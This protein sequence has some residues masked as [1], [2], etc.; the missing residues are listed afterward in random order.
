MKKAPY[1]PLYAGEA[2]KGNEACLIEYTVGVFQTLDVGGI[3]EKFGIRF[4]L[5]RI[6]ASFVKVVANFENSDTEILSQSHT[7]SSG[8]RRDIEL[9]FAVPANGIGWINLKLEYCMPYPTEIEEEDYVFYVNARE[10]KIVL[11]A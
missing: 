1:A 4:T 7:I 6:Q 2:L 9:D 10:E 8:D 3:I 11:N 5:S